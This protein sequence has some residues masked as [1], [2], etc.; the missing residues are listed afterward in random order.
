VLSFASSCWFGWMQWWLRQA[1]AAEAPLTSQRRGGTGQA[2]SWLLV[3]PVLQDH[4]YV[5]V[6]TGMVRVEVACGRWVT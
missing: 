5:H 6:G 1:K 2:L 3:E 4:A